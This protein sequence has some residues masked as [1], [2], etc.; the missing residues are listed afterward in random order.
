MTWNGWQIKENF[1]VL[2]MEFHEKIRAM[3]YKV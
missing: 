1:Q 2:L 3:P